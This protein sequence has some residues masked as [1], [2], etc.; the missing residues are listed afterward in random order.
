MVSSCAKHPVRNA[1]RQGGFTLME[2]LMTTVIVGTA[3]LAIVAAQQAYHMQNGQAQH[4]G[5]GLLLANELRELTLN[6]PQRDPITGTNYWGPEPGET[7]IAQYDDLDDFDGAAGEGLTISPPIDAT[8]RTIPNMTGWSQVVTVDNVLPNFL[9]TQTA[10][11][12]HSTS[13]VR[14]TC[15]VRFQP[16][17]ATAPQTVT[18]MTWTRA[19]E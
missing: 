8:G 10:A 5:A 4:M 3:V 6:L 13:V 11:P 15:V 18:Q 14:V 19:G 1:R 12:D 16:T 7:G 9:S 2:S 17:G